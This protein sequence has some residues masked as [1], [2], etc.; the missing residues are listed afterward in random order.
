MLVV[1]REKPA[2]AK[3]S[4]DFHTQFNLTYPQVPFNRTNS[5]FVNSTGTYEAGIEVRENSTL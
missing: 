4:G 5:T 2:K 1:K 3:M